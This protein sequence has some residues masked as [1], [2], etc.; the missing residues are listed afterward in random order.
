[1]RLTDGGRQ[2]IMRGYIGIPLLGRSGI[3]RR[4]G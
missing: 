3:W 2:I 1:M 4:V